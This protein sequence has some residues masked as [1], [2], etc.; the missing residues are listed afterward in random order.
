MIENSACERILL[1]G[2]HCCRWQ[3]SFLNGG[4]PKCLYLF[5]GSPSFSGKKISFFG[6][7]PP[8]SCFGGW[9]THCVSVQQ[10]DL[11]FIPLFLSSASLLSPTLA[12]ESRVSPFR[13]LQSAHTWFPTRGERLTDLSPLPCPI[14]HGAFLQF[15]H[16]PRV[17]WGGLACFLLGSPLAGRYVGSILSSASS[18]T[19]TLSP[20]HLSH[21][22]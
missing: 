5:H 8:V 10:A 6:K 11:N 20:F 22:L 18:V 7:N 21:L 9:E 14:V 13:F 16:L 2:G 1:S 12:S 15:F 3:A 19:S 17:P 4:N